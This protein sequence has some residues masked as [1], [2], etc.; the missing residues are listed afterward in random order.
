M[1]EENKYP[2]SQEVNDSVDDQSQEASEY[3]GTYTPGK[4][5]SGI[6]GTRGTSMRSNATVDG[7]KSAIKKLN[8]D[9]RS[10][11]QKAIDDQVVVEG[12][13]KHLENQK[14]EEAGV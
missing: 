7:V 11:N 5:V 4:G 8:T 12:A 6:S 13:I 14:N 1:E 2:Q 9:Q 10:E 3:K